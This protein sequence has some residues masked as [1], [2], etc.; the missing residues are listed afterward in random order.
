[1]AIYSESPALQTATEIGIDA[2]G[3][4]NSKEMQQ[5]NGFIAKGT[6]HIDKS[7]WAQINH[8]KQQ[9]IWVECLNTILLLS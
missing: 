3:T 8:N 6:I 5:I 1:M 4:P 2:S 9:G 7:I